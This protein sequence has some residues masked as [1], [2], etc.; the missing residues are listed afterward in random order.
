MVNIG[1]QL[2][3]GISSAPEY[4]QRCMSDIL[5]VLCHIDD[6]L[7]LGEISRSMMSNFIEP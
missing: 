1:K 7:F 4:F 6:S 3:F 5:E 2:P